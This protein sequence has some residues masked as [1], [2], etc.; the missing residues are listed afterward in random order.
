VRAWAGWGKGG[1]WAGPERNS[2]GFYLFKI[3]STNSN[4]KWFKEYLPL[5]EFFSNKLWICMDLNKEQLSL[6]ELSKIQARI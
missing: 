2:V 4:F 3:F 5:V 6:L 1:S